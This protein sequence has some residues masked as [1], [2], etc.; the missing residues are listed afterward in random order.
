MRIIV[1]GA[2][3]LGKKYIENYVGNN[4]IVAIADNYCEDNFKM[5]HK[6]IKPHEILEYDYDQV[7]ICLI[8]K[9]AKDVAL[10]ETVYHQLVDIGVPSEKIMFQNIARYELPQYSI[11]TQF[12][13]DL[14][15]EI[16]SVKGAVAECGVFRGNLAGVINEYFSDRKLYLMDTFTGFDE[17]DILAESSVTRDWLFNRNRKEFFSH[18]SEL[19]ALLRCSHREKVEIRKG[20]VP[21]TLE[22]LEDETFCFVNLDMDLYKPTIEALHFF[23]DRLEQNGVM[24]LHDYFAKT[25]PGVKQAVEEFI[26]SKPQ[27]TVRT[28]P[29]GDGVSLGLIKVK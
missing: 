4:E 1:F 17:S 18:G 5:G 10:I 21:D 20:F 27:F 16:K 28:F 19:I 25:L 26:E 29:I 8:D 2:G 13:K 24:L 22:G 14:A 15:E 3:N 23:Y 12:I 6:I 11:R 7:L 9:D